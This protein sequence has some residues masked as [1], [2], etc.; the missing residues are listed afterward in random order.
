MADLNPLPEVSEAK[1]SSLRKY[2]YEY[3]VIALV[4]AVCTLFG[5]YYNTNNYIVHTLTD[6]VSKTNSVVEKNTDVIQNL[7]QH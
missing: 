3:V 1:A 4:I 7:K 2:F 6:V 5:M